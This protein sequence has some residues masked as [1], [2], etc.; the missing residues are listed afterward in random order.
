M[1]INPSLYS[2][3]ID[4]LALFLTKYG[5]KYN[6]MLITKDIV[7]KINQVSCKNLLL[8]RM[9]GGDES[10]PISYNNQINFNANA[11]K[12][13][14]KNKKYEYKLIFAIQ[15]VYMKNICCRIDFL[16]SDIKLKKNIYSLIERDYIILNYTRGIDRLN[17]LVPIIEGK[18]KTILVF[19]Y[20]D[21]EYEHTA[22]LI[23]IK[24]NLTHH[25]DFLEE[26]LIIICAPTIENYLRH[27]FDLEE[28]CYSER[29]GYDYRLLFDKFF[30]NDEVKKIDTELIKN[31]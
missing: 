27:S 22:F 9:P 26:L 14:C 3:S 13:L 17:V 24:E 8:K 7:Y 16:H 18:C 15:N 4:I 23:N 20:D 31:N 5:I 19:Y 28:N 2:L 21:M 25:V 10:D 30:P 6:C 11:L 29:Y 1:E 12:L